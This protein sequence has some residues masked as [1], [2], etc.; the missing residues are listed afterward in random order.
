MTVR[1]TCSLTNLFSRKLLERG[2]IYRGTCDMSIHL[3]QWSASYVHR[4]LT[5][6][7]SFRK[8]FKLS[9]C[10]KVRSKNTSCSMWLPEVKHHTS[11]FILECFLLCFY[12][13]RQ[14]IHAVTLINCSIESNLPFPFFL[15]TSNNN[16]N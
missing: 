10:V 4:R 15:K 9:L 2:A 14:Y 11:I 12:I 1:E 3:V 8:I 5:G 16:S 13:P 6:R 7:K